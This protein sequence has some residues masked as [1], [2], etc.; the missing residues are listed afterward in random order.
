MTI[1]I[2]ANTRFYGGEMEKTDD[3]QN[4]AQAEQEEKC[5]VCYGKTG[6]K[7]GVPI[8]E[9]QFYFAGVGQLCEKCYAEIYGKTNKS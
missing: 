1:I 8:D 9:R 7:F 4:F 5:V 6:Y 3:K 2:Y